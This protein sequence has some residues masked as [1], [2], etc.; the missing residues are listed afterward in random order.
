[1]LVLLKIFVLVSA[2]FWTL[3]VLWSLADHV[4]L[5]TSPLQG[6]MDAGLL[7][8]YGHKLDMSA[9]HL[10]NDA[11]KTPDTTNDNMENDNKER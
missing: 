1:M 6:I 7:E 10:L 2:M 5:S 4:L 9:M 8:D 3:I 11:L